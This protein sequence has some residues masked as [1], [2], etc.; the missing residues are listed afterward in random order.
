MRGVK[1]KIE[2]DDP[3]LA[4]AIAASVAEGLKND[5][6]TRVAVKTVMVLPGQNAPAYYVRRNQVSELFSPT[7]LSGSAAHLATYTTELSSAE[8]LKMHPICLQWLD[9][10]RFSTPILIDHGIDQPQYVDQERAFLNQAINPLATK[11]TP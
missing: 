9:P 6:F 10:W 1:I 3:K 11:E 8:S 7:V 5:Q 4:A 2:C